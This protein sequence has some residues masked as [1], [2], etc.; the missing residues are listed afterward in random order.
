MNFE[1]LIIGGDN[2]KPLYVIHFTLFKGGSALN[3]FMFFETKKQLD[4]F[5]MLRPWIKK[6]CVIFKNVEQ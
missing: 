3:R 1:V 4:N 2:I 6:N 5:L